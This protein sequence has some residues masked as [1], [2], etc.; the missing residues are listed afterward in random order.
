MTERDAVCKWMLLPRKAVV[1][2]HE[3]AVGLGSMGVPSALAQ[4][5]SGSFKRHRSRGTVDAPKHI[6]KLNR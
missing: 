6:V 4:R 2:W 1:S 3:R 5:S